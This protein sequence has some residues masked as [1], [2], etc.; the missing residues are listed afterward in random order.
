LCH[1]QYMGRGQR[2]TYLLP[3]SPALPSCASLSRRPH[4][5]ASAS[6]P[7][8]PSPIPHG[9]PARRHAWASPLPL[10]H[11]AP[12]QDLT[13]GGGTGR[14]NV[15]LVRNRRGAAT[16]G[17]TPRGRATGL[18]GCSPHGDVGVFRVPE[19]ARGRRQLKKGARTRRDRRRSGGGRVWKTKQRHGQAPVAE[20]TE[21]RR[22]VACPDRAC[23]AAWAAS[24]GMARQRRQ[25]KTRRQTRTTAA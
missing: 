25:D 15:L 19:G 23:A 22:R 14:L 21:P 4:P 16:R 3:A 24:C 9:S 7:F 18:S 12:R 1:S 8:G 13:G 11:P 5:S 2:G 10:S 6:I 20:T 17:S